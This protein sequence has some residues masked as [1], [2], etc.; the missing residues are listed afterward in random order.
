MK[1]TLWFSC[2]FKFQMSPHTHL[3]NSAFEEG[4]RQSFWTLLRTSAHSLSIIITVSHWERKPRTALQQGHE[5]LMRR[6]LWLKQWCSDCCKNSIQGTNSIKSANFHTRKLAVIQTQRSVRC[7]LPFP[8][9]KTQSSH[10]CTQMHIY[11]QH[12]RSFC[13][14]AELFYFWI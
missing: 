13:L 3:H 9:I 5:G 6:D 2:T 8:D 10:A 14:H 7:M 12:L 4:W 11:T 1:H